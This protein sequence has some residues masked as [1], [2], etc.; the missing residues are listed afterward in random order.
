MQVIVFDLSYLPV[1]E[2]LDFH[3]RDPNHNKIV[4]LMINFQR[5]H[6]NSVENFPL[7]VLFYDSEFNFSVFVWV[8]KASFYGWF[9]RLHLWILKKSPLFFYLTIHSKSEDMSTS[10]HVYK[11]DSYCMSLRICNRWYHPMATSR[12]F[13]RKSTFFLI[14]VSKD[15]PCSC[16]HFNTKLLVVGHHLRRRNPQKHPKKRKSSHRFCDVIIIY[17]V[18]S[19]DRK[20]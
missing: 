1:A 10:V 17:L 6:S 11:Y 18:V 13:G 3:R 8:R 16:D 4:N 2:V 19:K 5:L 20:C 9:K 7:I 12:F 15:S 14:Y